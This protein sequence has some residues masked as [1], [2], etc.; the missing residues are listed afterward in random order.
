M[1]AVAASLFVAFSSWVGSLEANAAMAATP[2]PID[3]KRAF[4]YL[5]KICEIGP[6][7]A[8]SEANTRQ[9][10]MVAAHFKAAG[11]TVREQPFSTQHPLTGERVNMVNL[12]GSWHPERTRRVVIGGPLRH[13][14]SSR[15]GERPGAPA[16]PLPRR[17][18][19]RF[20]RGRAHGDGQPSER[21]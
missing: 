18:R 6:R 21:R 20:G 13:P 11:A 2:A 8:G 17:Q 4:G 7:I 15:R 1:L 16:A 3:G 19:R 12:I 10:Q 9:R 5:E 14:P